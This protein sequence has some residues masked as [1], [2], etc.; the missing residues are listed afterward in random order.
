ML[1]L[2]S[3]ELP[4]KDW[5]NRL[6][7][8][9]MG[10]LYQTE[11]YGKYFE[12][13]NQKPIFL[14]FLD[15]TGEIVGQ[16]LLLSSSP[17]SKKSGLKKLG[18]FFPKTKKETIKWSYGPVIFNE[19]KTNEIYELLDKF[20]ISKNWL[21]KGSFHPFSKPYLNSKLYLQS[22]CTFIIDLSQKKEKIFSQIQKHSGQKNIERSIERGVSVHEIDEKLLVEYNNLIN[23]KLISLNAETIPYENRLEYFNSMKKIGYKGYLAK[24][25]DTPIG[26][27]FFSFFNKYL[28][29]GGLARS[30]FD[31]KEKLYSQDLIK[32]KIIEWGVDNKMNWFDIAGANPNPT[33]TKEE[34]IL[35]YKKKWGGKQFN[36]HKIFNE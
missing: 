6:L 18:K 5:N 8:S 7:D 26:G 13:L 14:K 34:G 15:S 2:E 12:K 4:D 20:L 10:T 9:K 3:N 30:D 23:E 28:I 35:K 29:E 36:Y 11:D 17:F 24:K 16:L 22:W 21:I 32:W 31:F 1:S 33:N 25:D 19:L 27:L